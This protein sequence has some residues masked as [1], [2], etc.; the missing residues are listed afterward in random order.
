MYDRFIDA[1][2]DVLR[3]VY[4]FA[5]LLLLTAVLVLFLVS[6]FAAL[7]NIFR[8]VYYHFKNES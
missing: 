3:T 4:L 7:W 2:I 1:W 5:G 8:M 6:A